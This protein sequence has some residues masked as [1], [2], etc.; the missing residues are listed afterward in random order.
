ESEVVSAFLRQQVDLTAG[1]GDPAADCSESFLGRGQELPEVVGETAWY[2]QYAPGGMSDRFRGSP[3]KIRD[4]AGSWRAG[5]KMMLRFLEDA[6]AHAHTADRAHSGEAADAFRCYFKAFVGF[7]EPPEQAQPSETLVANLVAACNQIAKAC[8]RYADH[9]EA[10]KQK[11]TQNNLDPSASRCLG[12]SRC[13]AE[14]ATTAGSLTQYSAIPGSISSATS[15]MLW[16]SPRGVSGFPR[17]LTGLLGFL[18]RRSCPFP[19]PFPCRWSSPPTTGRLPPSSRRLT[20]LT[21]PFPR[22]TPSL[23]PSVQPA[24]SR[25]ESSSLSEPG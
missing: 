16:T 10:A 20:G 21:L 22:R 9:V 18:C 14:T 23:R 6:Q 12:T 17:D 25:P 13:S 15:P 1:M 5:G 24:C 2:D 4:V 8:D 19:R 3:E 11:I 7:T